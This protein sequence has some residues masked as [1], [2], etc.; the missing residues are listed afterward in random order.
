MY[1]CTSDISCM[2]VCLSLDSRWLILL[3]HKSEK[4]GD[5]FLCTRL[6][7]L[8]PCCYSY[9]ATYK[10]DMHMYIEVRHAVSLC[11]RNF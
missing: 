3:A 5:V 6:P 9:A 7:F 11:Y 4:V 8:Y 2:P 1:K 10:G